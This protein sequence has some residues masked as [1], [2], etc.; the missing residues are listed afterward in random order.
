MDAFTASRSM[1]VSNFCIVQHLHLSVLLADKQK[2]LDA[3]IIGEIHTVDAQLVA[4]MVNNPGI[5]GYSSLEL[6]SGIWCN[7]VLMENSETK[8]QVLQTATH[9]HA[10]YRLAPRYYEWIRLHIGIMPNG[11]FHD[12]MKAVST[13][14]YTFQVAQAKPVIR[15]HTYCS[16]TGHTA[17]LSDVVGTRFIASS[18]D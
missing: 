3:S 14:Y 4:E 2:Q 11:L 18:P 16:D 1:T 6:R 7:L 13:R 15:E 10:A 5:L 12:E 17:G 9:A 8:Q